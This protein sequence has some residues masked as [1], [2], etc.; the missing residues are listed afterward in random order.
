MS[1]APL[2]TAD[3]VL[4]SACLL[5]HACR[6]DGRNNGSPALLAALQG[7][8]VVPICPEAGAGLGTP[9]PPV[10]LRGGDGDAVL[11]GLARAREVEGGVD[12]TEAF[13][14]GARLAVAAARA[15]GAAAA[16]LK[17]RSPSCGCRQVWQDG[18]R[19]AGRGVA[20]A[21]LARAGVAVLSDE[22]VR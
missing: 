21:A 5:G 10:Q 19:V 3:V 13:R 15:H 22:E 7:K 9:R 17:E 14:E 6:H 18:A 12:R 20:A 16:V 1:G 8:A 11:D 4:V 2:D